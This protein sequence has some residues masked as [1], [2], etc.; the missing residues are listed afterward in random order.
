MSGEMIIL[1][2]VLLVIGMAYVSA[3]NEDGS[4]FKDDSSWFDKKK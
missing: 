1:V 4:I 2:L 3:T